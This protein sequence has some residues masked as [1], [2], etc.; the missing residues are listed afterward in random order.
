MT[1]TMSWKDPILIATPMTLSRSG[2][3]GPWM[4][5]ALNK[6]SVNAVNTLKVPKVT[7]NGGRLNFTIKKPFIAPAK[8]E[9]QIPMVIASHGGSPKLVALDAAVSARFA[10]TI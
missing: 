2:I 10:I 4:V 8:I 1:P 5:R 9:A 3:S 6:M 7:M